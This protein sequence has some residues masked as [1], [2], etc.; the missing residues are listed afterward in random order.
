MTRS[1]AFAG[2]AL[3]LLTA[4]PAAAEGFC[5]AQW[6]P[7]CAAKNGVEQTYSNL[8]CAKADA[9]EV[10]RQGRCE[11]SPPATPTPT[12]AATPSPT[13]EPTKEPVFCTEDYAPVCGVK[14]GASQTYSNACHAHADGAS[15]S[16]IGECAKP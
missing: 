13:P 1:P 8:G 15:V 10:V 12:P 11:D 16:A 9:A 14:D 2:L 5:T 4:A 3:A 6:A 7:V